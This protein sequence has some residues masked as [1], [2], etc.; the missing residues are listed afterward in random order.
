MQKYLWGLFL[1]FKIFF[2]EGGCGEKTWI[3][4]VSMTIIG[5]L[6]QTHYQ[7]L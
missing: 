1:F 7:V 4:H 5:T 3:L 2:S 6:M